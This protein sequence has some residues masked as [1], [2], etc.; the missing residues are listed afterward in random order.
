[1]APLYRKQVGI[2]LTERQDAALRRFCEHVDVPLAV[3]IRTL[4][5][6]SI[7]AEYWDRVEPPPGQLEMEVDE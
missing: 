2:R 5:V 3:Y 6:E 7:H 4:V 1:M